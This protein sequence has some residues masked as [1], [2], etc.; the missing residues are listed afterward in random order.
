[1]LPDGGVATRQKT[2]PM[3]ADAS[4]FVEAFDDVGSKAHIDLFF[5]Q[6][7][8]HAVVVALDFDMVVDVDPGLFPFGKG[9]G[10]GRQGL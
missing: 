1:M 3:A 10:L 2:A 6:P 4:V 8:R 5:D 9:V 7:V